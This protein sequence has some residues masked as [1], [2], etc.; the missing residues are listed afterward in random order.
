MSEKFVVIAA[1]KISLSGMTALTEDDRF[2]VLVPD[3]WTP[4][5]K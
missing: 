2:E 3:N 5:E 1:D 4:I